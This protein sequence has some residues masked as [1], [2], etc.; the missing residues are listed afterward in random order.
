MQLSQVYTI[1]SVIDK[2][3][4]KDHLILIIKSDLFI[5]ELEN[6]S[7]C[8]DQKEFWIHFNYS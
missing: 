7:L 8:K 3:D 4:H 2:V 5:P 6:M 1:L